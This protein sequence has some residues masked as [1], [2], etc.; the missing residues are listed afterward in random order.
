MQ[1]T[2]SR[3]ARQLLTKRRIT[4]MSTTLDE[5]ATPLHVLALGDPVTVYL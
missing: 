5:R 1:W 3:R 2:I 4:R